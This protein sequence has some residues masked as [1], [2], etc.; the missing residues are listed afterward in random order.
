MNYPARMRG[1]DQTLPTFSLILG[2]LA[3]L[4]GCVFAGIPL[5]ALSVI[6]GVMGLNNEKRDPSKYG[7]KGMAIA[8]I[9]TGVIGFLLSVFMVL[10]I[11]AG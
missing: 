8:G 6:L 3:F 4:T 7:G 5:G 1:A 10:V 11:I 2:I 9:V